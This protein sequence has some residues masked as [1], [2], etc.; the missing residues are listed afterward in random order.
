MRY[1][2]IST[3]IISTH[4]I[5]FQYH[6]CVCISVY[7][8]LQGAAVVRMLKAILSESVFLDGLKKYLAKLSYG[9]ANTDDL[10]DVLTKVSFMNLSQF[11][12]FCCTVAVLYLFLKSDQYRC[13][14]VLEF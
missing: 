9:N 14:I 2:M 13:E 5:F 1:Q 12:R 6:F 10:W 4:A 8:I 7:Q 11:C 3:R